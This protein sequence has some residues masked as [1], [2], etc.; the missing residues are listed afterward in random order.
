MTATKDDGSTEGIITGR[1]LTV[2]WRGKLRRIRLV[3][4]DTQ[5]HELEAGAADDLC[6]MRDDAAR[7]GIALTI[8]T[9][10]RERSH[11]ER[12][13]GNWLRYNAYRLAL[14]GWREAGKHGDP[15]KPVDWAPKAAA[16]GRST[17]EIGCAADIQRAGGDDPKTA[18]PDSPVDRWLDEHAHD[19]GFF[20]DVPGEAWHYTS[21]GSVARIAGA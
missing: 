16:P 17:H 1:W 3:V 11:Q 14:D 2:D 5:G 13:Y 10:F 7:D 6:R 20:R 15:P 21:V 9:A 12:L 4:V 19:Y 8:N 18:K